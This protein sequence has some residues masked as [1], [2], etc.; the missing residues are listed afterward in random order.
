VVDLNTDA[1]RRLRLDPSYRRPRGGTVVIGGSP[2]RLFRLAPAA[3]P[4]V[5]AVERGDPAPATAGARRLLDRLIDAGALHPELPRARP[6]PDRLTVVLPARGAAP[7]YRPGRARTILVDDAG[8]VPIELAGA[9][10]V[11]LPH[12]LGPGGARNA[13]LERVTTELVAF[14]DSDVD[15]DEASLLALAAHLDDPAVALVA[16]RVVG[17]AT[18]RT[19]LE[20]YEARRSPLDLGPVA[21]RVAPMSRVSYVPA[22]VLVCRTDDVRGLGGFEPSLRWGEDVDLVWRLVGAGR[23]C[24]YEPGVT[25]RHR[26][27]AGVHA[28][29]EQ[30]FRYGTSASVLA[31]RHPGALAPVR[32]SGWSALAWGAITL[33]WRRT[34][35]AVGIATTLAL[36]RKLGD[37]PATESLRLAGLGHLHAGRLLAR[38]ATRTWWPAAAAAALASRR[39]R[40]VIAVAAVASLLD[41]TSTRSDLPRAVEVGLRLLDDVAYG[42]GVWWGAVTSR[43]WAPLLPSFANWPPRRDAS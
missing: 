16:P 15:V 30:R 17:P 32:M 21:A 25:A 26:T 6:D 42:A 13:G 12:R 22:A 10:L 23:R 19:A 5:E 7:T 24:R 1:G 4:V 27:R 35:V 29:V 14:V 11:R 33:G 18:A 38:A 3:V 39:A 20:R 28:W 2:L 9:E 43:T 34:G 31:Q 8:E 41:G 36:V 40:P 37:V